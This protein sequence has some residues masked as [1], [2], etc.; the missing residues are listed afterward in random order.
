M[1][2]IKIFEKGEKPQVWFDFD[3]DT[4]VLI[5][6]TDKEDLEDIRATAAR[7]AKLARS[8]NVDRIANILLGKRKVKGWRNKYDHS[9]PGLIVNGKPFPYSEENVAFLMQKSLDFSAFV[10]EV[11][12]NLKLFSDAQ[13]EAELKNS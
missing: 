5:E 3:E 10:N 12:I 7:M 4:E 1:G 11:C 13:R 2:E 6:Y 8:E 9:H